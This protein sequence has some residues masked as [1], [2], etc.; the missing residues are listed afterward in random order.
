MAPISVCVNRVNVTVTNWSTHSETFV[1]IHVCDKTTAWRTQTHPGHSAA[2]TAI[3]SGIMTTC[4]CNSVL[5]QLTVS[6][7][8]DPLT[9]RVLTQ[10]TIMWVH[11]QRHLLN[12]A[13]CRRKCSVELARSSRATSTNNILAICTLAARCPC[14]SNRDTASE[15]INLQIQYR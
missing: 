3:Q 6:L 13:P 5:S 7:W 11:H 2:Q 12:C 4:L 8:C 10:R 9:R 1:C 14:S 15:R